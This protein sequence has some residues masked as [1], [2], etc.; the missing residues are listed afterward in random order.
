MLWFVN[1]ITVLSVQPVGGL[2]KRSFPDG[3]VCDRPSTVQAGQR[4]P[5]DWPQR[6]RT[7]QPRGKP[8]ETLVSHSP[9][10]PTGRHSLE[11]RVTARCALNDSGD[12]EFPG[13]PSWAIESNYF[14]AEEAF[15]GRGRTRADDVRA[16]KPGA[17][18][19]PSGPPVSLIVGRRSTI[20]SAVG[21]LAPASQR[22]RQRQPVLSIQ[23]VSGSIRQSKSST[24]STRRS[25]TTSA[26]NDP[27]HRMSRDNCP[28]E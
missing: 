13:L 26:T 16:L 21:R 20:D 9:Q 1:E 28:C 12:H 24:D 27:H 14:G 8:W 4:P 25:A 10:G 2:V 6:G 5:C 11:K 18:G 3:R 19:G 15:K 17:T 22:P 23:P 7:R